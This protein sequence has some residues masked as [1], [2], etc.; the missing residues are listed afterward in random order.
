M[1]ESLANEIMGTQA[2][3]A[4]ADGHRRALGIKAFNTEAYAG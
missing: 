4:C 1:A 2:E 3:D